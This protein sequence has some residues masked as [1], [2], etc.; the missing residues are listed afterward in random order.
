MKAEIIIAAISAIGAVASGYAG[1]VSAGILRKPR[2]KRNVVKQA[3][4]KKKTN[5]K[6]TLI[7]VLTV[8][9]IIIAAVNTYA[10]LVS[11][12]ILDKPGQK[13]DI[14]TKIK[15]GETRNLLFG[16]YAWRVLDIQGDRALLIT[17]D[18]IE[19]RHYN[20]SLEAVTWEGCTLRAYLNGEF[21]RKFSPQERR[22]ISENE[23]PNEDNQWYGTDGGGDTRDRV[24]LLSLEEVV[25]HFGDSGDLAAR[26]GWYWEDGKD[27]LKDG[28]GYYI[29]DQ[30]NSERVAKFNNS[31]YWWWLRS[32]GGSQILAAFV[33]SGGNVALDGHFVY[34]DSVG[35][36]PALWLN[37]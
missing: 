24:F 22:I 23:N 17:E 25:K 19:Q 35:V 2:Q 20:A 6:T 3:I 26:K 33:R 36:R 10:A 37:L 21:C 13:P 27:V 1:L 15:R 11:A 12:G 28:K 7:V 34:N 29:N 9:L 14:V 5:W 32:P 18:V 8:V 4:P 31:G 16:P 30:Y